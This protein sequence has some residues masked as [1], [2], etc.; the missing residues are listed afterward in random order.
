MSLNN[1]ADKLELS[2]GQFCVPHLCQCHCLKDRHPSRY[3]T[4]SLGVTY[5]YGE[6]NVWWRV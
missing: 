3:V 2:V 6:A 1:A 4:P 5:F